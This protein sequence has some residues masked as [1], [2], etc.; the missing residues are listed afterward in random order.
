MSYHDTFMDLH[1]LDVFC[2]VFEE[3]SFSQA[4]RKLDLSQP[5]VSI[6]VKNLEEELGVVL[7]NRL[8][9]EIEPTDA[10]RFLYDRALG[11]LEL[12]DS[13]LE[14]I[15]GFHQRLEGVLVVGA[16]TI[17]GEYLLPP[18]LVRLREAHP[19]VRA[20]V[21]I[22]DS[23]EV[24]EDVKTGQVHLGFVGARLDHPDLRYDE[25]TRDR[26]VWIASSESPW[27][28]RSSLTLE[29]LTEAPLLVREEGSGTRIGFER[30][31]AEHGLALG[32]FR[33]AAE[34]G[35]TAAIKEAVRA[36][37]GV[38]YLSDHAVQPERRSGEITVLEVSDL[39]P[40]ERSFYVVHHTKRVRSPLATAFLDLLDLLGASPS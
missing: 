21:L 7:F 37:L 17:P 13:L 39:P 34:L 35:S 25:L 11:M 3:K 36:G 10:A 16:S 33:I 2:R 8:G 4:A 6:H 32:R 9:R 27:A 18:V 20:R 19:G 14:S 1:R 23:S 26:L 28:R 22:K 30:M 5:T 31:L 29:D 38:S 40:V 15:Q 24:I 12:Q